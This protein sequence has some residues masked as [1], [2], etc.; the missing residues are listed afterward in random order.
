MRYGLLID[1]SRCIGC[2]SCVVSCKSLHRIAAGKTGRRRIKD[3]VRG[4]Y[5]KVA[6]WIYPVSCMHCDNAPCILVCPAGAIVQREDGIVVIDKKR[7]NNC[8]KECIPACPYDALY[9][10]DDRQVIDGCDFCAE[11]V[12]LQRKPLC[13]EVC[14]GRVMAFGDLADPESGISKLIKSKNAVP[15]KQ[16]LGTRPKVYYANLKLDVV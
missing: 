9:F 8:G 13:V 2:Y 1:V 11:R 12:G 3:I 7:C 6:R 5:P 4:E 14:P 10:D 16:N 15:L